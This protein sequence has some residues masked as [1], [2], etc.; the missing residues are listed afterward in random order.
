MAF[1]RG[2]VGAGGVLAGPTG[3][4]FGAECAVMLR[5]SLISGTPA[6]L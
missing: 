1:L 5:K 6:V 3:A 2:G 4:V